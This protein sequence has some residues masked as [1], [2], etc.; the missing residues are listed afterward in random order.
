MMKKV[1]ELFG[2]QVAQ[3]GGAA[4]HVRERIE[5]RDRARAER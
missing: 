3:L 2:G 5:I 1:D 4:E